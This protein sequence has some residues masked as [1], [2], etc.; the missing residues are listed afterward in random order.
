MLTF[1]VYVWPQHSAQPPN[2]MVTFTERNA[3][4][5]AINLLGAVNMFLTRVRIDLTKHYVDEF[6]EHKEQ[7]RVLQVNPVNVWYTLE[8]EKTFIGL[9][10][11]DRDFGALIIVK[12]NVIED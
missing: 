6:G 11:F 10:E 7:S 8:N 1:D 3:D 2:K 4:G 5:T 12:G 9:S